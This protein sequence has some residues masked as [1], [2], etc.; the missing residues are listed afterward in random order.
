M[1][2]REVAVRRAGTTHGDLWQAVRLVLHGLGDESGLP[3][4]GLP[5]LGGI[6]DDTGTDQ[7]LHGLDLSN[8]HLLAATKSLARVRDPSTKRYRPVDYRNLGAEELGSIYE[9]LLELVPKWSK[10]ERRFLLDVMPGNERKNTGSYYTP[11]SL[12][13]CLL[14][15]ALDPVLDDA[16]KR[17]ETA[18][19][20]A[21]EDSATAI[22]HALLSVTVCDPACGSGTSWLPPPA[23]LPSASP[24]FASTTP[25]RPSKCCVPRSAMSSAAASSA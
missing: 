23:A 10:E 19:T 24:W 12:I 15:T 20:A 3:Q 22:A 8:E 9:S 2:L 7:I 18:A 13:D 11:T 25:N 17:A 21:G 6:Y 16:Q 14:D 5:G 4:L 1:R